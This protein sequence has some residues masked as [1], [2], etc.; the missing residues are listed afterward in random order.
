MLIN[1]EEPLDSVVAFSISRMMNFHYHSLFIIPTLL[2]LSS[3][4]WPAS[5]L[6]LSAIVVIVLFNNLPNKAHHYYRLLSTLQIY[7]ICFKRERQGSNRIRPLHVH[8]PF[9]SLFLIPPS[10]IELRLLANDR[11][12][13]SASNKRIQEHH[14][15]K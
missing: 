11:S 3:S 5:Q 4:S 1:I 15:G 8:T 13:W 2:I 14:T 9:V 10:G 12:V 7:H 6:S